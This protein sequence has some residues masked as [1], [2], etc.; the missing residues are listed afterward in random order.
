MRQKPIKS[1]FDEILAALLKDGRSGGG[2]TEESRQQAVRLV[3]TLRD[4]V[5][6]VGGG[7]LPVRK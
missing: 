6:L 1:R 2:L 3:R 5:L 7:D 4:E